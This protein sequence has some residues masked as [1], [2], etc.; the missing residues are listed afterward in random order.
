MKPRLPDRA[1]LAQWLHVL[2]LSWFVYALYLGWAVPAYLD[3]TARVPAPAHWHHSAGPLQ[4]VVPE[5]V[6]YHDTHSSLRIGEQEFRCAGSW[7]QVSNCIPEP[8]RRAALDG[9]PARISWF[10]QTVA[11]GIRRPR[12][13]E[14]TVAGQLVIGQAYTAR[15]MALRAPSLPAFATLALAIL[16][17]LTAAAWY[18]VARVDAHAAR[19]CDDSRTPSR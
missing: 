6:K 15:D 10:E 19:R 11:P 18:V 7:L 3:V 4:V 5:N 16:A 8:Y 13:I 12:L 14:M 9:Q 1:P 17:A 2:R